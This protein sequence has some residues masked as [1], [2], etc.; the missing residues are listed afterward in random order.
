MLGWFH[1]SKTSIFTKINRSIVALTKLTDPLNFS[2]DVELRITD[3][4]NPMYLSGGI[5]S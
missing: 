1:I 3:C 4:S 5:Y 2:C